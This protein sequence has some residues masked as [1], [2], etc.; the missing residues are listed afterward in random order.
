MCKE[1]CSSATTDLEPLDEHL[2]LALEL[3]VLLRLDEAGAAEVSTS[4]LLPRHSASSREGGK[5]T[6]SSAADSA[7]PSVACF[8]DEL[9]AA[10][11]V[12]P[13]FFLSFGSGSSDGTEMA[14]AGFSGSILCG[15]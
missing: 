7:L 6:S 15:E 12:A 2:K 13:S 9:A 8:D 3:L 4:A 5:C 14:N 10:F 1:E 11:S